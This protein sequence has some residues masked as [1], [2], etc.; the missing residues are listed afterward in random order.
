MTYVTQT[1][2]EPPQFTFFVNAPDM[3]NNNF[4][5]YL[6]NRLRERFDLSGTPIR[7]KYK[8]KD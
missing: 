6:E 1:G 8:K 7:L 2:T 4:E 3:I 5:R